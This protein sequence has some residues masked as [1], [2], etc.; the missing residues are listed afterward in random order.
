MWGTHPA[1]MLEWLNTYIQPWK[2]LILPCQKGSA[3]TSA[4]GRN[5]SYH[6]RKDLYLHLSMEGTNYTMWETHLASMLER[7]NTYIRPWKELILP[8]QKGSALISAHGRN[9]SYHVR[10]ALGLITSP[11]KEPQSRE[12]Q[13]SP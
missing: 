7:L 12:H 1:S 8:C 3:L 4:H 6:V 5:Q 2:D 10:K 9:Q 11:W 13:A